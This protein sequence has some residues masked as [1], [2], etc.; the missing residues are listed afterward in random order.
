VAA[1][2]ALTNNR[3][4]CV[5]RLTFVA[6]SRQAFID[7]HVQPSTVD[8]SANALIRSGSSPQFGQMD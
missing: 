1:G 5:S 8:F 3:K 7:P 2:H 4:Q 6:R